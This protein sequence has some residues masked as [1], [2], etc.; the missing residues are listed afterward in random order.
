MPVYYGPDPPTAFDLIC[1]LM[2]TKHLIVGLDSAA[3]ERALSRLRDTLS[4]HHTGDGVLFDSR[5]S[6]VTAH[7]AP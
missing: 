3:T 6:I 1:D 4:A 2:M 7:R 5:S